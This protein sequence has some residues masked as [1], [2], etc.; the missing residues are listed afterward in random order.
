VFFYLVFF[1]WSSLPP[2]CWVLDTTRSLA[3]QEER[4]FVLIYIGEGDGRWARQ[5]GASWLHFSEMQ[6]HGCNVWKM[7]GDVAMENFTLRHV[8]VLVL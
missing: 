4:V 3:S 1:E 5:Q 7:R 6:R 2:T 8:E